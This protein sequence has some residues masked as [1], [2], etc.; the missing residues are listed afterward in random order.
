MIQEETPYQEK[1]I[2]D[3]SKNLNE[4]EFED[5]DFN[6]DEFEDDEI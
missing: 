3:S 4:E 1:H 2:N 6:Y 5:D